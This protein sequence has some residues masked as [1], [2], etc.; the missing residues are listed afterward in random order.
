MFGFSLVVKACERPRATQAS[1]AAMGERSPISIPGSFFSPGNA[2][3]E[4][5]HFMGS[6]VLGVQIPCGIG[7]WHS[8]PVGLLG[9]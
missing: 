3:K 7:R 4:A 6:P 2:P 1:K 5:P 8:F 9:T